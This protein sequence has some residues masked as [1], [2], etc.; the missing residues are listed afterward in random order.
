ML[1]NFPIDLDEVG[2]TVA[3]E[4]SLRYRYFIFETKKN[5]PAIPDWKDSGT[6]EANIDNWTYR[7][8]YEMKKFPEFPDETHFYVK[9]VGNKVEMIWHSS[10]ELSVG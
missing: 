5:N 1:V 4:I 3:E 10:A 2:T 7:F 9:L 8:T 6:A